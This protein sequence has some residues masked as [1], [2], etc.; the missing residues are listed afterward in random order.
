VSQSLH[1]VAVMRLRR[2]T[3]LGVLVGGSDNDR[4]THFS[5]LFLLSE[6][7]AFHSHVGARDFAFT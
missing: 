7:A 6:R 4:E 5:T 3:V 1:S 2:K